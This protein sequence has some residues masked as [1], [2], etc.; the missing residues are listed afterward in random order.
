M[1][2]HLIEII[3]R[4]NGVVHAAKDPIGGSDA[5]LGDAGTVDS[6]NGD[7][8]IVGSISSNETFLKLL[9]FLKLCFI[10]RNLN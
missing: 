3:A 4:L 5:V 1:K 7:I 9:K 2:A 8:P 10:L 6:G